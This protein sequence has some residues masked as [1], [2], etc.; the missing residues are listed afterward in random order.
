MQNKTK[1]INKKGEANR[2]AG[3]YFGKRTLGAS[4]EHTVGG[5]R[6]PGSSCPI[7]NGT[8]DPCNLSSCFPTCKV[9]VVTAYLSGS[10][11]GMIW[12]S[13]CKVLSPGCSPQ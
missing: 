3:F 10:L 8:L 2:I 7:D 13:A 5:D 6:E 4:R 1:T 9:A 11:R 12:S